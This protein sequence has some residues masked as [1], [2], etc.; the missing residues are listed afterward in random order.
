MPAC[1][2]CKADNREGARFCDACGAPLNAAPA[3]GE[4][5]ERKHVTVMFVDIVRSMD[6]AREVDP[7]RWHEFLEEFYAAASAAVQRL[8]G[9]MDKFTGDGIMALFGAPIA[10]EDHAVRACRAALELHAAM[11]PL[12]A[13][14]ADTGRELAVRVGVNSGEV[15][16]GEI[17]DSERMAYTAFGH[18]VGIAQRMESVAP[19]GATALSAATARLVA[20][21][22]DFR[23][24]GDFVVKGS[25]TPQPV[26]QLVGHSRGRQFATEDG[27]PQGLSS[28]VGRDR[29][30]AALEAALDR[31]LDGDGQVVGIVGEPGVGKSRLVHDVTRAAASAGSR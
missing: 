12:A 19:P 17:G 13:S 18:A 2:R 14:F 1:L 9:T 8:E 26:F 31:A 16:V 4:P 25:D 29:E 11:A 5:G 20:G 22:L 23:P 27:G 24:L 15:I 6:H 7:E 30:L 28:L 3:A 21:A 10:H